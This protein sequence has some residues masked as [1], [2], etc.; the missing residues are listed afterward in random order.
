LA[1]SLIAVGG[2]RWTEGDLAIVREHYG[3]LPAASIALMLG[4]VRSAYS[5]HHMARRLGVATAGASVGSPTWHAHRLR[6][7]RLS[8]QATAGS[9]RRLLPRERQL[10]AG[11]ERN[12]GWVGY[13]AGLLDG[14]GSIVKSSSG[15]SYRLTLANT[16]PEMLDWLVVHVGGKFAAARP[17]RSPHHRPCWVWSVNRWAYTIALLSLALPFLTTK[18]ER[19]RTAI[20]A[21][22]T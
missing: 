9:I 10:L 14:E 6:W 19:A 11:L 12:P 1:I 15:R 2:P 4:G 16:S 20:A 18:A 13:F 3:K 7:Q 8:A 17:L 22:R 5:V 21:Y